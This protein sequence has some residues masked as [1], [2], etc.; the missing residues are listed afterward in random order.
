MKTIIKWICFFYFNFHKDASG[1]VF[2][3]KDFGGLKIKFEPSKE[4]EV[5]E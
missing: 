2:Y 4:S 5:E 3:D 1:L